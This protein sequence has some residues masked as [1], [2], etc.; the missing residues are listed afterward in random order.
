MQIV[1][2]LLN[3]GAEVRIEHAYIAVHMQDPILIKAIMPRISP[4]DHPDTFRLNHQNDRS[5][6]EN[7]VTLLDSDLATTIIV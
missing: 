1:D 5:V 7:A 2:I 4:Y 6:I 3:H